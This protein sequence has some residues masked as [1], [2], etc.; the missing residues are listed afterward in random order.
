MTALKNFAISRK[1]L[2]GNYNTILKHIGAEK[3]DSLDRV[4]GSICACETQNYE[5]YR[6]KRAVDKL[7]ICNL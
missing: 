4:D 1:T 6:K 2:R 5:I 3:I 7:L